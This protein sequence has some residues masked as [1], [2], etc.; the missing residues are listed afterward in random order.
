MESYHNFKYDIWNHSFPVMW[1]LS[2]FCGADLF[3]SEVTFWFLAKWQ[4]ITKAVTSQSE[5]CNLFIIKYNWL[6]LEEN[7]TGDWVWKTP[8][9]FYKKILRNIFGTRDCAHK[10][11][12]KSLEG[13]RKVIIFLESMNVSNM[14]IGK[15]CS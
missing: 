12:L 2:W 5:Y 9:T 8:F 14:H 13:S 15:C 4:K 11:E 7:R 10:T 3:H 6:P 1:F